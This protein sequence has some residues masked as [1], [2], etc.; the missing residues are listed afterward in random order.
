MAGLLE[1][2]G[3]R[4]LYDIVGDAGHGSFGSVV[5]ARLRLGDGGDEEV[6]I[7]VVPVGNSAAEVATIRKEIDILKQSSHNN[8]VAFVTSHLVTGHAGIFF[9]RADPPEMDQTE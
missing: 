5:R 3:M 7:K 9:I 1:D 6:A 2:A 4:E 8:I